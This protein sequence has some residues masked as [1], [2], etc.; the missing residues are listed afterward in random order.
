[1]VRAANVVAVHLEPGD[2]YLAFWASML[3]SPVTTPDELM[4]SHL[5]SFAL[6]G[7]AC[8]GGDWRRS[9]ALVER[10]LEDPRFAREAAAQILADHTFQP[11]G[12]PAAD[13]ERL[14]TRARIL[15][16]R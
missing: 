11:Q 8:L 9:I 10:M 3:D 5:L 16:G 4:G 2:P 7:K 12:F 15:L 13:W 1:M 6:R 14:L